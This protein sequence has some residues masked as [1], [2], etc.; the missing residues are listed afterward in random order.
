MM[1]VCVKGLGD[2]P[3]STLPISLKKDEFPALTNA[4][5]EKRPEKSTIFGGPPGNSAV[6]TYGHFLT[7][8][9]TSF[10][11]TTFFDTIHLRAIPIEAIHQ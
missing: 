11:P 6:N 2:C 9:S 5:N 3:H 7:S 8:P 1:K 10:I 4:T